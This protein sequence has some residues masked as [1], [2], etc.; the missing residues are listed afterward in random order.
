MLSIDFYHPTMSQY[1]AAMQY[2]SIGQHI[3]CMRYIAWFCVKFVPVVDMSCPWR[4]KLYLYFF[5]NVIAH[6]QV[7]LR[8]V[9]TPMCV[10]HLQ[11]ESR[12]C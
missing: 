1:L 6:L 9:L 4:A 5:H 7:F 3:Y 2:N 11:E 12:P 10:L 8:T